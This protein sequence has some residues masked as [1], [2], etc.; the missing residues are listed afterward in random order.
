M[1]HQVHVCKDSTVPDHCRKY[2]LSDP[3]DKA[4][5]TK[6]NHQHF[7]TCDRCDAL[8]S[9]LHEIDGAL[10]KMSDNNVSIDMKEELEF[11]VTNAKKHIIAWKAH[12]LRNV[13]QDEARLNTIEA[14]NETS[15][16]LVE[17]WAMKFIPRKY[18]EIQKDWFGKKGSSWHITVAT[19]R[20]SDPEQLEIMTFTHVFQSCCSCHHLRCS[21]KAEEDNAQT[22]NHLS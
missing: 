1:L 14:L 12:L 9:V 20:A 15:V 22:E 6:C 3:N 5:Q 4:F 10:A 21:G 7:N 8:S 2:A 16:W 13:N 18:Q 11:T 19:R 17:D